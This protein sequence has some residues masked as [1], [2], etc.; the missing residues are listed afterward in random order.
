MEESKYIIKI[1]QDNKLIN[2][3]IENQ[4]IDLILSYFGSHEL[5]TIDKHLK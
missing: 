2:N 4:K 5:S 3:I 1:I